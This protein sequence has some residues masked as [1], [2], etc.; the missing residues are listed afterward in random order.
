M[1]GGDATSGQ[2]LRPGIGKGNLADC[3]RR[4]TL[5]EPQRALGQGKTPPS[6]CDGARGYD[7]DVTAACLRPLDVPHEGVQPFRSDLTGFS[8]HQQGRADLNDD[9]TGGQQAR[10]CFAHGCQPAEG[11]MEAS[12]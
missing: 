3:R 7:D 12:R 1:R 6:Q 4:L 2:G 5:L 9:E 10:S 8:V 11:S